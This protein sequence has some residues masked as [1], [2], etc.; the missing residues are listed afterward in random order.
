[1][2]IN[3]CNNYRAVAEE[4]QKNSSHFQ[5]TGSGTAGAVWM[6]FLSLIAEGWGLVSKKCP[7]GRFGYRP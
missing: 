2:Y 6:V 5:K 3:F 7:N 1:M 4:R